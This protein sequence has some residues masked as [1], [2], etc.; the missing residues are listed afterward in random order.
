MATMRYRPLGATGLLV[1]ELSFGCARIA[2]IT[3]A[4]S[5]REIRNTIATALDNGINFFDT[6]DVYGQGDSERVLGR[7]L[8]DRRDDVVICSKA[9]LVVNAPLSIIRWIKPVAN[10]GLRRLDKARRAAADAR[11]SREERCYDPRY[12]RTQIEGSLRR[13]GTDYLDLFLLHS[14]SPDMLKRDELFVLMEDVQRQGLVRHFGV[15]CDRVED[16]EACLERCRVSALQIPLDISKLS[17]ARQAL[18]TARALGAGIIA[19]EPFAGGAL[20]N[21]SQLRDI[22]NSAV[23]RRPA[24]LALKSVL[25]EEAVTSVLVGTGCRAHLLENLA[26]LD[27]AQLSADERRHLARFE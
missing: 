1:S 13:L 14:P 27:S 9:G 16:L 22:S 23:P 15:S 6:A 26:A 17:R 18:Q 25:Q 24:E 4:Y 20:L 21:H 19:R 10:L 3:T 7:A 5:P 2:S 11:K 12:I 8:R